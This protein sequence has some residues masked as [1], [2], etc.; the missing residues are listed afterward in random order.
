MKKFFK[1]LND[2]WFQSNTPLVLHVEKR[3]NAD[4]NDEDSLRTLSV[5]PGFITL[6]NRLSLQ[7]VALKNILETKKHTDIRVVDDLQAGL[8]WL[9]YLENEVNRAV[10]RK[11]EAKA[12]A[13]K[14]FELQEFEKV[15]ALY[16]SV[17]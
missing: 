12:V 15:F 4:L 10:D 8:K 3:H 5:H 1:R 2:W 9:G 11:A 17:K 14:P 7:R 13:S 6:C 16:Q